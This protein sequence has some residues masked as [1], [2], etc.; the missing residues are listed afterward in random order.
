MFIGRVIGMHITDCSD[1]R[2]TLPKLYCYNPT[3][4][5][6]KTEYIKR[7]CGECGTYY[8]LSLEFIQCMFEICNLTPFR[9]NT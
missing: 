1:L 6:Q 3:N 7:C 8:R 2:H 5:K 4:S 9:S